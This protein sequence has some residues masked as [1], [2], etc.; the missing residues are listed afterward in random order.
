MTDID[1]SLIVHLADLHLAPRAAT[2]AKLDAITG[3]RVRDIDMSLA[4]EWAVADIVSQSPLPSV[5]LIAGDIFDTY[6]G[7]HQAILDAESAIKK[8]RD[9]GIAVFGIAGNHDTPTQALKIPAFTVLKDT[10]ENIVGDDHVVLAYDEIK[11][12]IV[13]DTE[14]VLLPH[15]VCLGEFSTDDLRPS[16]TVSHSVLVVHGVAAGDP[17][18]EQ[19][20]ET[21]EIPIKRSV[22]DMGW[23]YVA[24]GHYHKP[25][26]IPGYEGRAAYCGS[27]ENTV[28]SGNDVCH[29][30]GPVYVKLG[31]GLPS[32]DMHP[33]KIRKI[34]VLDDIDFDDLDDKSVNGVES[35]VY[36]ALNKPELDGAIVN[37]HIKGLPYAINKMLPNRSFASVNSKILHVKVKIDLKQE[38][39]RNVDVYTNEVATDNNES[40]IAVTES[41]TSEDTSLLPL[42]R[43]MSNMLDELIS[44]GTIRP[45]LR[46]QVLD[47]LNDELELTY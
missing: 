36:K 31:D 43:E 27:L 3:R 10:F 17:S 14:Y 30:R 5:C 23:D 4:L 21:K 1:P 26:W 35:A 47:I 39:S 38:S 22:L 12:V 37:L 13:E 28:I 29:R 11:K 8:L 33:Q 16:G 9:A 44:L 40:N 41:C 45:E 20:D 15:K 34:T 18:L 19:H 2:V 42:S 25:G 6:Q 32:I 7:S 24:F 46:Q